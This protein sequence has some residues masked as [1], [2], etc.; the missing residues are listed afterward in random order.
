LVELL[1]G[2]DL[3]C[4]ELLLAR[5]DGKLELFLNTGREVGTLTAS[6]LR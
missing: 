6:N 2:G 3:L 5:E 4:N 1:L